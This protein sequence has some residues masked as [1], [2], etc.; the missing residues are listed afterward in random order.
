MLH[1]FL[2]PSA[3][4]EK[5]Q[6]F[7]FVCF[8]VGFCYVVQASPGFWTQGV[9]SPTLSRFW[10]TGR[11]HHTLLFSLGWSLLTP[12]LLSCS[13]WSRISQYMFLFSS[14]S[15]VLT[16]LSPC[17]TPCL[18]SRELSAMPFLHTTRREQTHCS[19]SSDGGVW[20]QFCFCF[21]VFFSPLQFSIMSLAVFLRVF[22]FKC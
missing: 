19:K 16:G 11:C 5:S 8:E 22:F 18:L 15:W 21:L 10:A 20:E 7:W 9:F 12:P 14:L 2:V 6:C 17:P 13:Q 1:Y 4:I 3:A